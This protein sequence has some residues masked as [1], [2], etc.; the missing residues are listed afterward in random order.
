MNPW[1]GKRR[2]AF[3]V[4]DWSVDPQARE[5]VSGNRSIRLEPLTM[6][7]LLVLIGNRDRITPRSEIVE[8]LWNRRIVTD[9]AFDRQLAKLR[10]ALGDGR[11]GAGAIET[12]P[13]TGLRLTLPIV[14]LAQQGK[15]RFGRRSMPAL[16]VLPALAAIA[17]LFAA[18]ALLRRGDAELVDIRPLTF[19]PGEEIEPALSRDGR[20]LVFAARRPGEAGFGLY[21]RSLDEE[22]AR[23]ITPPGVGARRPAWSPVGDRLAFFARTNDACAVVVGAP[24]AARFTAIASC[25]GSVGGL[26]WLGEDRLIVADRARYGTPIGLRLIEIGTRRATI[27]T[28]PA[29]DMLGDSQPLP[30][31]AGGIV[32]FVRS[33]FLGVDRLERLDLQSG[34][35]REIGREAAEI[36]GIGYGRNGHILV[37]ATRQNGLSGL[38]D[39]DPDGG[40]WVQVAPADAG[41]L[42]ASADGRTAI[43]E[44]SRL[45]GRIW[46]T[47]AAPASPMQLTNSSGYDRSPSPSP[48]RSRLAFISNRSGAPAIWMKDLGSGGERRLTLSRAI[49]PDFLAWAPNGESL[50]VSG[51]DR[52]GMAIFILHPDSGRLDRFRLAGQV[53]FGSF[54]ADGGRLYFTRLAGGQF[55]IVERDLA[56]GR[57]RRIVE[58]AWRP[59]QSG[60]DEALL[61]VRPFESG[62]WRI[63]LRSGAVARLSEWPQP[64]DRL[65]WAVS[66]TGVWVPDR[67]SRRLLRLDPGSGAVREVRQLPALAGSSGLSASGPDLLFSLPNEPETDLMLLRRG[68][69][70]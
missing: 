56:S 14:P 39:V 11:N 30:A 35:V 19:D 69:D 46:Q 23:R 67:G 32:Y 13:K 59:V 20:W 16:L 52:L 6:K 7:L 28:E 26:A 22:S 43:F 10:A 48:D 49:E 44:Q 2:F 41:G 24:R 18:G 55:A 66:P 57:E 37:S 12:L 15:T 17:A 38:W 64:V 47:G 50:A 40:D 1:F 36:R 65:N 51:R 5:L 34:A 29:P 4:G 54:S 21:L 31:G 33:S 45:R 63:D 58:N 3:R 68:V 8:K 25:S 27:V 42:S 9:D 53:L 62:L 70:H 61:F 60:R